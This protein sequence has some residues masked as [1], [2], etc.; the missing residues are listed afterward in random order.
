L[1]AV[2]VRLLEDRL[3]S[4]GSD[5]VQNGLS[6]AFARLAQFRDCRARAFLGWLAA[7]VRNEALKALKQAGR[8]RPL[9]AGSGDGDQ[10]PASSSGPDVR[11][12]RREQAA[13]LLAA[14]ERLP[15]DYRQVIEL[16]NFQEL[17]FEEVARHLGR[18]GEAVRQLWARALKKLREVLR[19]ET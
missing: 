3:P 1:K 13:R 19:E 15:P 9:P 18:S 12:S 10:V 17:P 5:V 7:I 16:R 8:A 6:Q 11:A 2:P 14:V 4:D